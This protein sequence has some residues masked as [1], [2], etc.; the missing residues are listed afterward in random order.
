MEILLN[1]KS[2]VG[3]FSQDKFIEFCTYQLLPILK[4][5]QEM[6]GQLL[7]DYET[8]QKKVTPQFTLNDLL[9]VKGNPVIDRLKSYIVQLTKEPYWNE[10]IK[11]NK[12]KLYKC[13][14]ADIP[15]CITEAFERDGLLLSFDDKRFSGISI[16]LICDGTNEYV[17]NIYNVES[18]NHHLEELGYIVVWSNNS[19]LVKSIGYKFEVRFDEGHHNLAHFH[20]SNADEELSISIPDADIIKGSSRNER[21]IVTW[22]L[23]NMDN[24]VKLWNKTEPI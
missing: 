4:K 10:D 24:I 19:F 13:I 21:K 5:I 7:K 17:R 14:I 8:Y 9:C 11:T 18:L 6:N 16:E 15:N 3:Q 1:D 12:N 20:M 2:L 23:S 22:A